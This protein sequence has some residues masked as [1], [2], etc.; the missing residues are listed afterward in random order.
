MAA[1]YNSHCRLDSGRLWK[2]RQNVS[3]FTPDLAA[4]CKPVFFI[5]NLKESVVVDVDGRQYTL[6]PLP[7]GMV[8]DESGKAVAYLKKTGVPF[9][10]VNVLKSPFIYEYLPRF[11][12]FPTFPQVYV[13]G[14]LVGGSDIVEE[15][16]NKGEL[17]AMIAELVKSGLLPEAQIP[18]TTAEP[19]TKAN[20]DLVQLS[21]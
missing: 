3:R 13:G 11:S 12:Q 10:H 16:Y 5:D 8:W 14:E 15:L 9:A 19:S 1:Q 20:N 21:L 6:I 18:V 7:S 4:D 2:N 17:Q